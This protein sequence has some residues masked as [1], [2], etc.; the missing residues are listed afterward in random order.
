MKRDLRVL[1]AAGPLLLA[2]FMSE[3][4][5]A[6]KQGI[7]KIEG[8][9]HQMVKAAKIRWWLGWTGPGGRVHPQTHDHLCRHV[10]PSCRLEGFP[11]RLENAFGVCSDR[12]C[13]PRRT[14]ALAEWRGWCF[15]KKIP[16]TRSFGN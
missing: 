6:Q 10:R 9:K 4:A 7:L 8:G 2:M 5:F 14:I 16:D 3:A 11:G 1:A 12:K 15:L 13:R